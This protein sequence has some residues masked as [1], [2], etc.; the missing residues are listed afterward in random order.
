MVCVFHG[1]SGVPHRSKVFP[2]SFLNGTSVNGGAFSFE[3]AVVELLVSWIEWQSSRVS[4]EVMQWRQRMV[5]EGI[6]LYSSL[7][8]TS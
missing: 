3:A 1:Y 5:L 4:P 8:Y 2:P 7:S 6:L